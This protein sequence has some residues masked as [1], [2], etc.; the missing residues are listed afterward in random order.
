MNRAINGFLRLSGKSAELKGRGLVLFCRGFSMKERGSI[1][2]RWNPVS[3]LCKHAEGL[4]QRPFFCC[5]NKD[6]IQV[7]RCVGRRYEGINRG[8]HEFVEERGR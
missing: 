5:Q 7:N 8:N 2:N 6:R 3:G 4:I 1:K